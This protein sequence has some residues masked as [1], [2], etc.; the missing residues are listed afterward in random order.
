M[1][2]ANNVYSDKGCAQTLCVFQMKRLLAHNEQA[3]K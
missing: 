1:A 2:Y 3:V